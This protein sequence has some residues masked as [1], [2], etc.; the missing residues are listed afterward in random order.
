MKR[1]EIQSHKKVYC[2]RKKECDSG[3]EATHINEGGCSDN[4]PHDTWKDKTRFSSFAIAHKHVYIP[5]RDRN[6]KIDYKS[7]QPQSATY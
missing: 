4:N 2:A 3:I 5:K 6:K 1:N 7:K